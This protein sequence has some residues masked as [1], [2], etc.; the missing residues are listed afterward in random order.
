MIVFCDRALGR[1]IIPDAL[2]AIG[3]QVEVHDAHFPQETRD[4]EWLPWVGQWGWIVLTKDNKMRGR[5]TEK[6]AL[7]T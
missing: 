7:I 4:D 6:D 2:R 1:K 5:A 3:V